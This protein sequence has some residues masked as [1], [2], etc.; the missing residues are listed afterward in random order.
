MLYEVITKLLVLMGRTIV[1]G[2]V[3][4]VVIHLGLVVILEISWIVKIGH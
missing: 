4:L 2:M 3:I 1:I